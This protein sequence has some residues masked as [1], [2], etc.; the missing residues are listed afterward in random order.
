MILRKFLPAR[1]PR[2]AA[3]RRDD[4]VT[5]VIVVLLGLVLGPAACLHVAMTA[6]PAP[7]GDVVEAAAA[8]AKRKG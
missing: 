5:L 4:G 1:A 3:P 6:F 2:A 7:A 8:P